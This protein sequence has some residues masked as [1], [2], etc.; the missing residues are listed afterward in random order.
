MSKQLWNGF[1]VAKFIGK[2]DVFKSHIKKIKNQC[3][4]LVDGIT[5]WLNIT[6]CILWGRLDYK[7]KNLMFVWVVKCITGDMT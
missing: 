5:K 4:I 2:W 7:I 1:H 3:E 6:I